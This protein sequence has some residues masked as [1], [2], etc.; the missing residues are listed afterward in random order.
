LIS[1]MQNR[2]LPA[3]EVD[4]NLMD[5]RMPCES[6]ANGLLA[7]VAVHAFNANNGQVI[8]SNIW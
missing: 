7:F 2:R 8:S 1:I 6:F 4:F 5:A 3:G